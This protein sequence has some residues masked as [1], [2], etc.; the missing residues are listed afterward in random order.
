MNTEE[1]MDYGKTLF[2][3]GKKYFAGGGTCI[4]DENTGIAHQITEDEQVLDF[5]L[6][7]AIVRQPRFR[8]KAPEGALANFFQYQMRDPEFQAS[9]RRLE[10]FGC[11][12]RKRRTWGL[13]GSW[14][15]LPPEL[16]EVTA[17]KKGDNLT[18]S[19]RVEGA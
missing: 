16:Q 14:V 11:I 12:V 9:L 5:R 1:K 3:L 15:E 7:K 17:T 19:A 2:E 6:L 10:A 13:E 18:Y 4:A 8:G